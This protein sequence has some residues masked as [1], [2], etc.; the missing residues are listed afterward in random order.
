MMGSRGSEKSIA[1]I[2][3]DGAHLLTWKPAWLPA[4]PDERDIPLSN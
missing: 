1:A 2:L 4:K 3:G